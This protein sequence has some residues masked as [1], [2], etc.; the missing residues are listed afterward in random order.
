MAG[1]VPTRLPLVAL[2]AGSPHL[3]APCAG[4]SPREPTWADRELYLSFEGVESAFCIWVNDQCVGYGQDTKLPSEFRITGYAKP[5]PNR[6]AVQVMRFCDGS[7][8]E[9]QDYWHASGIHR[10]VI[11]YAKPAAHIRARLSVANVALWSDGI[12]TLYR[13]VVVLVDPGGD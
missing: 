6:L 4:A 8:L 9:D 13:V 11:L 12:P 3:A 2:D 10:S 1:E 7:Y 5:G